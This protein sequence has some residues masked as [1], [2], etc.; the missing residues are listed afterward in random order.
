MGDIVAGDCNG[1]TNGE[2]ISQKCEELSLGEDGCEDDVPCEGEEEADSDNEGWITP[3]NLRRVCEEMGGV[4][5]ELS[6]SLAVGC[7]TTDFAM[8][9]NV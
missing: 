3:G 9:V 1:S 5:E 8:Q 4:M 2:D 7:V 6:Q